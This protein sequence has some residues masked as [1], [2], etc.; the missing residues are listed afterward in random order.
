MRIL[1]HM[2]FCVLGCYIPYYNR[3]GSANCRQQR[4]AL[5]ACIARKDTEEAAKAQQTPPAG[6]T[7]DFMH[8]PP[9]EAWEVDRQGWEQTF[10]GSSGNQEAERD[11]NKW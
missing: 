1:P 2:P 8:N 11:I 9:P 4:E 10:D 6:T 7:D 5:M 3:Q